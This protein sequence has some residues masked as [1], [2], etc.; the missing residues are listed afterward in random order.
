[1]PQLNENLRAK[2]N[3]EMNGALLEKWKDTITPVVKVYPK[4]SDI[5]KVNLAIVC[6]N[7]QYEIDKRKGFLAETTQPSDVGAYVRHAFDLIAG[8][9]ANIV[10]EEVVSVQALKQKIGQIFF[11]EFVYGSNKGTTTK[12]SVARGPY[13]LN[14]DEFY[15]AEEIPQEIISA[16]GT[17]SVSATLAYGPVI[18]GSVVITT[19]DG[20][21][22]IDD[23]A[24]GFTGTG[25]SAGTI[26]YQTGAVALTFSSAP[27]GN[28]DAAYSY[29]LE[30]APVNAAE[31]DMKIRER[32]V[33]AKPRKLKTRWSVD[34]AFDVKAQFGLDME[35]SML[36]TTIN[37]IKHEIDQEILNDLA[38]QAGLSS[39]WN[40]SHAAYISQEDHYETFAIE[41]NANANAIRRA[42]RRFRGNFVIAGINV[43]TIIES[44]KGFVPNKVTDESGCY[45]AG[46]IKGKMKV[47]CNPF[48]HDDVWVVG[49]KGDNFLEAGYVYAPYIPVYAT[50]V[51]VLDDF[52]ARRGLG[53]S[54]AKAMLAPNFYL[55]GTLTRT[56]VT[57]GV[58]VTNPD[59]EP[60]PTKVTNP[61]DE[62]IP[63]K[64]I[65]P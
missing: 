44:L 35:K 38:R 57:A 14:A 8:V 37:E 50:D 45:V 4:F 31:F 18:A 24:G 12:G 26:D 51:I 52:M 43:L 5:Q 2:Y 62:P 30:T 60:I 33:I 53:T 65:T 23:G 40:A 17:T 22:L 48:Y 47:I 15:S 55:K 6:E 41:L 63:T 29:S 3:R 42:T 61:D 46:T 56:P 58:K 21:T 28:V 27:T 7:A 20:L 36:A 11:L 59:D 54:Y 16:G 39:T 32:V 9:Q 25:I 1:M 19:V 64:A 13:E 34:T 10:A 49:Y